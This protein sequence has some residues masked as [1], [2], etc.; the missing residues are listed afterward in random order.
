MNDRGEYGD[1]ECK[2]GGAGGVA[3]LAAIT[4]A[5]YATSPGARH[6]YRHGR[7][8]SH[9]GESSAHIPRFSR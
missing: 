8:P 2:R 6:W 4:I 9:R 1:A 3:I 7:L 5:I